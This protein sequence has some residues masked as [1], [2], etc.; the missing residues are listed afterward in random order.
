MRQMIRRG[1]AISAAEGVEALTI[2][3]L[4]AELDYTPGA[5]YRYFVSKDALIAEL[6]RSVITFLGAATEEVVG[7]AAEYAADHEVDAEVAALMAPAAAC[8]GFID[9]AGRWP[10][11]F[12]FLSV[13]VSDPAFRLPEEEARYVHQATTAALAELA[14]PLR[15]A[16]ERGALGDGDEDDRA[17]T[18][19]AAL[20][21]V[22]QTRKTARTDPSATTVDALARDLVRTLLAG[23]GANPESLDRAIALVEEHQLDRLAGSPDDLLKPSEESPRSLRAAK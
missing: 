18:A 5:L 19:W 22:L 2:Q 21:G 1:L 14:A 4:A 8:R 10:G 20:Q 7:R 15:A 16:A 6:Q 11:E 23:W 9:F 12:G 13:F 3:R 17:R